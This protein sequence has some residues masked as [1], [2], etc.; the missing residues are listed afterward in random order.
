MYQRNN[1]ITLVAACGA[2]MAW[3]AVFLQLYLM[4]QY[5]VEDLSEIILRFFSYFTILTNILVAIYFT[6]I[7]LAPASKPGRFILK[8]Q[9]STA[10]TVYIMVVGIV[11]NVVLRSLWQP[12]GLQLI[13]DELLH[14][15]IPVFALLYWITLVNKSGLKWNNVF[16]WLIYPLGYLVF[17]LIRGAFSGF[18]PYPFID[19]TALGYSETLRNSIYLFIAFL[20]LSI[21]MVFLAKIIDRRKMD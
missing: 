15:V 12:F 10:I 4:I 9:T 6:T 7:G 14:S 13:V 18:Y 17:V 21:F 16:S 2:L 8:A 19:V 3:L 5:R 20:L 11:Y 1:I